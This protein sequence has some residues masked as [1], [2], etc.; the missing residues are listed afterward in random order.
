MTKF[1]KLLNIIGL[2]LILAACVITVASA[3]DLP[4]AKTQWLWPTQSITAAQS[5]TSLVQGRTA[6]AIAMAQRSLM[7]TQ[8][9]DRVV[10]MHN[11]CIGLLRQGETERAT[12]ACDS[13]LEAAAMTN[14]ETLDTVSANIAHERG[15]TSGVRNIARVTN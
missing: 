15:L 5:T 10:G 4:D 1:D 3:Q 8:G 11:L 13:A 6:R 7:H 2:T 12:P 14:A 9:H